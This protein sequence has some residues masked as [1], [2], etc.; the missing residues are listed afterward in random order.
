MAA[1]GDFGQRADV[2]VV[3]VVADQPRGENTY[4]ATSWPPIQVDQVIHDNESIH[5]GNVVFTARLTPG[6]HSGLYQLER[7]G[8]DGRPVAEHQE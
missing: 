7:R 3:R 2:I 6:T 8:P 4:H 5:V 1:R